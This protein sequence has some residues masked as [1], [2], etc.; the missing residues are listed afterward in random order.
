M[1][2]A[3]RLPQSNTSMAATPPACFLN[4]PNRMTR[5]EDLRMTK[6]S[7]IERDKAVVHAFYQ[8]GIDGDLTSFARYLDPNF[9][10]TAPNYLPWGGTHT[11]A[12]LFR[13]QVLSSLPDVFDFARFG[14]ISVIAE[15]GHVDAVINQG[16]MGTAAVIQIVDCWTVRNGKVTSIWVAY[17]EP[18]ALLD[19][20]G[21]S[22]GLSS[23]M[24]MDFQRIS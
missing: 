20:L 22:H 14:Y 17:F 21:L 15:D 12:T 11:G 10:W 7:E 6:Q 8:A 2:D 5:D 24:S 23:G 19:K 16:V 3:P 1:N 18:Q 9:T 4:L 13:D